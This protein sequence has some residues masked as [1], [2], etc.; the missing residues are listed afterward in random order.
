[1]K[2]IQPLTLVIATCA[3]LTVAQ[4]ESVI[5]ESDKTVM[6]NMADRPGTVVVGN[7]AIADVSINGKTIFLHGRGYGNTNVIVLD[8]KGMQL[9][10]FDVTTR[11]AQSD[12]VTV[13]AAGVPTEAV[14]RKSYV[15]SPTCEAN[16]QIGD[17]ID[18]FKLISDSNKAKNELA[19]GSKTAEAEAPS[20]AQ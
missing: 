4:A 5:L 19:T 2:F 8:L 20:A 6:V 1:M 9:A 17:T 12:A 7:P 14:K 13:F 3:T 18:Q 16:L 11:Q 10:N 15:C